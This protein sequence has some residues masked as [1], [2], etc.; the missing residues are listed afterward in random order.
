MLDI[1]L[2][3][4][5]RS[6]DLAVTHKISVAW[7]M[8]LRLYV[9]ALLLASQ[10]LLLGSLIMM[11]NRERP[12]FVMTRLA[13][14][15]TGERMTIGT[16]ATESSVWHVLVSRLRLLIAWQTESGTHCFSYAFILP[17]LIV[18][19]TSAA[20]IWHQL[21][22]SQLTGPLFHAV[23]L[24]RQAAVLSVDLNESDGAYA[25]DKLTAHLLAC[26]RPTTLWDHW[27][28]S[29]HGNQLIEVAP[30]AAVGNKL[31]SKLYSLTILLH[32]SGYHVKMMR[33][34]LEA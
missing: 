25:N 7:V 27:H 12:A 8:A 3:A 10:N 15:E 5:R 17:P 16:S 33:S 30:L 24:L 22:F 32:T 4:G 2:S 9:I 34:L 11:A 26:S 1:A 21:F 18:P 20:C 14:D 29:L 19:S 13:W 23:S 31:L 28:C 6:A